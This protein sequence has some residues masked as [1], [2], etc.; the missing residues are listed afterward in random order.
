MSSKGQFLMSL[1][2][3]RLIHLDGVWSVNPFTRRGSLL[4]A[5]ADEPGSDRRGEV[6]AERALPLFL[7]VS[8]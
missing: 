8:A 4:H 5:R 3:A 6:R 1:D 7:A 2:T